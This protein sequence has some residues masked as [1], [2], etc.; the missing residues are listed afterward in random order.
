MSQYG[1]SAFP[2]YVPVSERRAKAEKLVKKLEK[3]GQIL[4]PVVID[5]R[6]IAKTFWG[7]SWC[8]HLESFSD[9]ASRL[10]RGRTY[11]RNGSVI[12]LKINPGEIKAMVSGSEIYDVSIKINPLPLTKWEAL[13]KQCSGKIESLIELLQGKF[14][15]G[16]MEI[17]TQK[18][19]GMFP[20]PKEI[21]LT[22][23]CPDY[24]SMCK[25][26]A[27]VLYGVGNRLD[28][29]PEHLFQ[30]RQTNHMDLV[31]STELNALS[32][33]TADD[34][35]QG[36]L[37]SLFG[38]DFADETPAKEAMVKDVPAAKKEPNRRSKKKEVSE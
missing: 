17:I 24:A 2:E 19:N 20:H 33:N 9:Y 22:C 27:A 6:T 29:Q 36:D 13:V 28:D 30:L 16:V 1:Y 25:H 26:V 23:S 34:Q 4:T 38:I 3:Q 7:K 35:L 11:A 18:E 15:K 31:K 12:D 14:S 8:T 21:K 5:G 32:I 37:S 10:P